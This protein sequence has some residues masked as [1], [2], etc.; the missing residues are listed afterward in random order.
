MKILFYL[1]RY[2]GVG[3]IETVTLQILSYL[4]VNKKYNIDV[5]SHWQE[6][7]RGEICT[8]N[9][10]QMPNK[11][12]WLAKEN[13]SFA[14]EII[15]SGHYNIIIY[16]DSYAPTERIVCQLSYQY[17]IPLF[18][19]EHNSPLFI[20]NKHR[21][22]S[23]FTLK[24]FLRRL[25]HPY[26]LYRE[27]QRKRLLLHH[28]T[29]YVLLSEAYIS[30]FC[31]LIGYHNEGKVVYINNPV[32]LSPIQSGRVKENI[33]LY[34]G[35]LVSEKGVDRM[36]Y[37]WS[38]ISKRMKENW[39]FFIVGDGPE[40]VRLERLSKILNLRNIH[41]EGYQDPKPYY[42]RAK[43][44]IMM[45]KY[46]GWPLTL[47]EAMTQGVVPVVLN[48]FS[49]AKDIIENA[50]N[51]FLAPDEYSCGNILLYLMNSPQKLM[52]MSNNAIEKSIRYNINTII[53]QWENLL[54]KY[55]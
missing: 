7:Q 29:R 5:L 26:L 1:T 15:K 12:S 22:A 18:V 44:F 9:V 17:K 31:N 4:T 23:I 40:R 38:G 32:T 37:M 41:F 13:F 8:Q 21:L 19:F 34:V 28:A 46:E 11:E 54:E 53:L 25:L 47:C 45:S 42:I 16:Q 43:I 51:G 6:E 49:A 27:K 55:K 39:H 30:E 14:D 2:P 52:D 35:R 48:T 24:G 50:Y 10:F 3:G 36:L 20:Y 33:L